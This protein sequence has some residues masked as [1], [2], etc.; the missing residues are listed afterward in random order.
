MAQVAAEAAR[1]LRR[2]GNNDIADMIILLGGKASLALRSL[3]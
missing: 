1:T 2:L 3:T